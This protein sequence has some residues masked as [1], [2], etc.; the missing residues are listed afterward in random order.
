MIPPGQFLRIFFLYF[1][2]FFPAQTVLAASNIEVEITGVEGEILENIKAFLTLYQE[3]ENENVSDWRIR[4][5]YE[6]AQQEIQQALEP[7]G[8]Y[9][10]TITSEFERHEDDWQIRYIINPG[11]PVLVSGV[12][13]SIRR[14]GEG[15]TEEQ[16]AKVVD[17][18]P[19]EKGMVLEHQVYEEG[20]K[21]LLEQ[22]GALG[23]IDAAYVQ[24]DVLVNPDEGVAEIVLQVD[25]GPRYLFGQTHFDQELLVPEFLAGYLNYNRGE[26]YSRRKLVELQQTLSRTNYF[27][28]V[29]VRGE[30]DKAEGLYIPVTVKL[31]EPEYV[32][33]YTFGIG[34]ATDEGVRGRIGWE[35]RLLNRSGH[36]LASEFILAER[37]TSVESVYRI[38]L[39]DPRYDRLFLGARYTRESW[40]NTDTTILKGNVGFEHNGSH[41]V[42][43]YGLELQDEQYDVGPESDERF[44]PVGKL[45]LSR[46][47][48][49]N[50]VETTHGILL[51]ASFKG[52]A[53]ELFSDTTFA[54]AVVSG[55]II[56]TPFRSLRL[57]GRFSLG[58]T[59]VEAVEDLP[60][61]LR[62]YAGGDNSVRGFGFR[63]LASRNE[64]GTLIGGK[65]LLFGSLELEKTL[66]ENW[67]VAAFVDTGKGVNDLS[68]ELGTGV[69]VGVRYRLPFG[70]FRL[71]VASAVS[72]DDTPL[73]LHLSIGTDL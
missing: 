16:I 2:L 15:G 57:I 22:L 26:P 35:N 1:L 56:T 46:I 52:A 40:E 3:K 55:K 59:A 17:T 12:I 4:R 19:L 28:Q 38:P 44:L 24:S 65:Y 62:F 60:P 8:Y 11:R 45:F 66:F 20:K 51:S 48:A 7:F 10:P 23:Y 29:I 6:M 70:Q 34:F 5:M 64:E 42:Y 49:D 53:D 73:R 67:G 30:V 50:P 36:N 21:K 68:E 14:K 43:N 32:N 72:E 33:R 47:I 13:I 37:E 41:F 54:Q 71:D 61:S 39:Q 69:G 27:G 9:L 63:E 58:A 25:T 18:F 31:S